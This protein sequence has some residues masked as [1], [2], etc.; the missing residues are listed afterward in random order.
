MTL[1]IPSVNRSENSI[2]F[3]DVVRLLTMNLQW[4]SRRPTTSP[5]QQCTTKVL[6][7]FASKS[8][9]ITIVGM[10]MN[11]KTTADAAVVENIAASDCE[12]QPRPQWRCA[13]EP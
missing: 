10:G 2:A 6:L 13:V 7:R 9:R 5:D 8:L 3:D 1:L 12:H 4:H 11:E